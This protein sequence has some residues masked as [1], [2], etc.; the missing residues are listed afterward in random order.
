MRAGRGAAYVGYGGIGVAQVVFFGKL[1]D[2]AGGKDRQITIAKTGTTLMLLID[3]IA[4]GDLVLAQALTDISV[5]YVVN[6]EMVAASVRVSD[7]D[8]IAFLPPV[9]GG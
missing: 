7:D 3:E 6:G 8:E 1:G 9:S 4:N 5:R 2:I